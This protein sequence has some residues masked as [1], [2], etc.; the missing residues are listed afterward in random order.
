MDLKDVDK[1]GFLARYVDERDKREPGFKAACEN[2]Y[3]K[4][5]F[6]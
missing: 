6:K 5:H 3:L 4:L 1:T 2:E